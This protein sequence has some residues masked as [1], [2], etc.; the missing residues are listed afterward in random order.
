MEKNNNNNNPD[1]I[2]KTCSIRQYCVRTPAEET[3]DL[4]TLSEIHQRLPGI[5]QVF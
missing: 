4:G 3:L 5:L 1:C 2:E